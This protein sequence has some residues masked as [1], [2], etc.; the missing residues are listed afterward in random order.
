[1]KN[2]RTEIIE[3]M[4]HSEYKPMTEKQLTSHFSSSREDMKILKNVVSDLEKEGLIYKTKRNTY[5][6]PSKMGLII[7]KL[8]VTPRGYGFV[9]SEERESDLF[10]SN[11]NMRGALNGDKV[12][13]RIKPS[14][15]TRDRQEG[16]IVKILEHGSYVFV[17]EYEDSGRFG[18]VIP[19]DKRIHTDIFIP[20]GKSKG[21]VSGDLV[22]CEITKFYDG[23][24]NPE[25]KVTEVIGKKGEFHV[26]FL[27]ILKQYQLMDEFPKKA[28]K[29]AEK[30]PSEVQED[31][32]KNRLDLREELTYT[33]DGSDTRDFDDA[34]SVSK[35]EH[36]NYHLG[37]H[38]ADVTHYV[39][40]H[41][42]LDKEALKRGTSVYLVDKVIPMLPKELSNGICSLNPDV[43]RLTLSCLMTIDKKGVVMEHQIVESVIRSKYRLVYEDVS[44]LLETIDRTKQFTEL[45]QSLIFAEELANILFEVREHRGAIEFDFPESKVIVEDEQVLDVQVRERKIAND[46]IQEFMLIANETVSK[47]YFHK[48]L[49]FVYRVH[50]QPAED[51]IK[52]FN[53]FIAV[54]GVHASLDEEANVEPKD[55]QKILKEVKGREEEDIISKMML[56]SLRQARYSPVNEGHFGLAAKYYTHFT[57]PIRRYPDLQIHRIIKMDIHYYLSGK[58][59]EELFS[60]VDSVSRSSSD[61]E[62]NAEQAERDFENLRKAQYMERF[63][64][65]EFDGKI[66]SVTNFG[67]F[68]TLENTVEGLIRINTLVDDYYIYDEERFQLVGRHSKKIFKVGMKVRVMLESVKLDLREIGFQFVD[69]IT[70]P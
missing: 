34:I 19:E 43:D 52:E 25:G 21:A 2:I 64:G 62:R 59:I 48:K 61:S 58:K 67:I 42:P 6:I 8:V 68:V 49:P 50:E 35:D 60:V 32:L 40:E 33:I 45:E 36:G 37:V 54:F 41:T 5:G 26:D 38:I 16:E 57:A 55:L 15:D 23:K 28:L 22:E 39:K 12:V 53:N 1:M 17:G 31:E 27:S 51:K 4:K 70:K 30:I 3:L 56:R 47:E 63:I 9:E 29:Q 13:A 69:A 46:M 7:G 65:Q 66:T 20:K 10:I 14:H 18:F 44:H 11:T 24:R